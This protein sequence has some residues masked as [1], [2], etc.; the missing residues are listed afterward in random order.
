MPQTAPF[1]ALAR[2]IRE[3]ASAA[4][5][6]ARPAVG[7]RAGRRRHALSDLR[8]PHRLL[9]PLGQSDRPAPACT[10]SN[11]RTRKAARQA[12]RSARAC[13]S[14]NFWQDIA[15]DWRK[16]RVYLPQEDLDALRRRRG[17]DRA[18]PRGDRWRALMAFETAR[19]RALL[20]S[21]RPLV[22]ALPWRAGVELRAVLA[23]GTRIL[24]RH[25]RG[26]AATSFA[27]TG[28][29]LKRPTGRLSRAA[30]CCRA[31]PSGR[32]SRMTPDEYCQQKAAQS[33]SSF[34]YSFLFLPP[35]RRARHHGALRVLP[36]SRRRRRRDLRSERRAR[37]A[38]VVA[39]RSSMRSIAARPRH[40]VALA[41]VPVVRRFRTAGGAFPDRHRRHGRWTSS[42]VRYLDFAELETYCHRVAGVVGL[43]SAEIF[44]Y[45]DPG[46][47]GLRARSRHRIPAD[48]HHSRRRRGRAAR[49]HLPAAGR[50]CALRR[51]GVGRAAR[52]RVAGIRRADGDSRSSARATWYDRALG[53]LPRARSA[54][55]AGRARHGRDLPHAARRDRARRLP[56]ARSAHRADAAAQALDRDAR[57]VAHVI[58]VI[59][60]GWA[61]CAAAVELAQSGHARRAA[62][63]GGR[64][65]RPRAARGPRRTAARQWRTPAP[66]CVQRDPRARANSARGRREGKLDHRTARHSPVRAWSIQCRVAP[67][68]L[69][70]CPIRIAGRIAGCRRPDVAGAPGDDPPVR[71]LEAPTV[72]L[73][74]GD[75]GRHAARRFARPRA[76]RAV[77]PPVPCRAE[78]AA[79]SAPRGRFS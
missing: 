67:R 23:G 79:S 75:D 72:S 64:A 43:M 4:R 19:T 22:R 11:R 26:V 28:R 40:P 27:A 70:A 25:R 34:Y 38:R 76:R 36:R 73:R 48:E 50:A 6:V 35:E 77:G 10:P 41:L 54:R 66:R 56:R 17:A 57:G 33:G 24:E 47:A 59:G 20:E 12:T 3:H 78:H 2:A 42:E 58:A 71:A 9:P 52:A 44:G 29:M 53:K 39:R 32:A 8:G 62:R 21:G 15:I 16:G 18:A 61:G 31:A 46:D 74:R 69:I 5:A 13:N 45:T 14:S 63:V 65:R 30:R 60:G 37:Q 7:V 55:A 49:P 1:A 68:A 51:G